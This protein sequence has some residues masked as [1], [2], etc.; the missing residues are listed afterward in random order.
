MGGAGEE[1][2]CPVW[3]MH[4]CSLSSLRH[5]T[6]LPSF[7]A[8]LEKGG[9]GRRPEGGVGRVASVVVVGGRGGGGVHVRC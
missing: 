1:V 6:S 2:G 7:T 8:A 4:E 3:N 5:H 9:G